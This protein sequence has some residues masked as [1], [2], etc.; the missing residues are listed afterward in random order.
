MADL[1]QAALARHGTFQAWQAYCYKCAKA[2][3]K[4]EKIVSSRKSDRTDDLRQALTDLDLNLSDSQVTFYFNRY[5]SSAS[6][7][8]SG[9][10]SAP[11]LAQRA[12]YIARAY[13]ATTTMTQSSK[14]MLPEASTIAKAYID[15]DDSQ[16]ELVRSRTAADAKEWTDDKEAIKEAVSVA[17]TNSLRTFGAHG[18]QYHSHRPVSEIV[19]MIKEVEF[20]QRHLK[21]VHFLVSR[22]AG[23]LA[24]WLRRWTQVWRRTAQGPLARGGY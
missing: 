13:T 5:L 11:A 18:V 6:V 14:N 8:L 10:F 24:R 19:K 21:F 3:E 9:D 23:E 2:T 1:K 7:S 17:F 12:L 16:K 22:P 20:F 4:R 15:K